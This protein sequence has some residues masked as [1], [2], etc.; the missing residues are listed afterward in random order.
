MTGADPVPFRF[1]I[2]NCN[3]EPLVTCFVRT[4]STPLASTDWIVV[5]GGIPVPVIV[6]PTS[7]GTKRALAEEY[8]AELPVV[9]PS[10]KVASPPTGGGP[11][12]GMDSPA[13]GSGRGL[14]TIG[15]HADGGAGAR[16]SKKP[17]GAEIAAD[18]PVQVSVVEFAS[19]VPTK[20]LSVLVPSSVI[21]PLPTYAEID[22]DAM[23]CADL[24]VDRSVYV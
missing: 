16:P 2:V 21:P 7:A 8:F 5:E 15:V 11:G 4:M 12:G 9:C 6:F 22:A 18:P 23:L 14:V 3:P 24:R 19:M 17:P 10:K 13:S 20:A 1:T